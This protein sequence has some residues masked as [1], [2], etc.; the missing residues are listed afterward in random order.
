MQSDTERALIKLVCWIF[1]VTEVFAV[2]YTMMVILLLALV[3]SR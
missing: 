3:A 2:K 1:S